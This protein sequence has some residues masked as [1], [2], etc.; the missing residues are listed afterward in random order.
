MINQRTLKKAHLIIKKMPSA[1]RQR[2]SLKF[3]RFCKGVCLVSFAATT[4]LSFA[5][6]PEANDL[7]QTVNQALAHAPEW[8]SQQIQTAA[9][10]EVTRQVRS[11]L[12]PRIDLT[13][14]TGKIE[15]EP[16]GLEGNNN[17]LSLR[18]SQPLINLE[19]WFAYQASK[20][21]RSRLS[22]E[23]DAAL[24]NFMIEIAETYLSV[25]RAESQ[26]EFVQA[27]LSA[28]Q[29]QLEQTQQRFRVGLIAITDVHEAQAANDL[30]AVS[31]IAANT[32]L[33]IAM[34]NLSRLTG[35]YIHDV[36]NLS[37]N[38]PIENPTPNNM[39]EWVKIAQTSNPSIKAAEQAAEITKTNIREAR[40][41]YSPTVGLF[42]TKADSSNSPTEMELDTTEVGLQVNY[43]LFQGLN[44]LSQNKQASMLH[45]AAQE[46]LR[47][48]KKDITQTTRN[49]FRSVQTD[50]LRVE[51]RLQAIR[52]SESA[53]EA[54]EA[55]YEVGTRN[56]VDVL[57]AQR[58]L[59]AAKRDLASAKYDYILNGLRLE[60]ATG[61]LT[62]E[63]LAKLN[64]WFNE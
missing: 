59:F 48:I 37:A 22:H 56:I 30:A 64:E 44:V 8:Q 14:Q 12:L 3:W 53:L 55:G 28:T 45:H 15:Y 27:E 58:S 18:L 61:S 20:L 38:F 32:D 57:N 33:D 46:D 10:Q 51:A 24:H 9:N 25:L 7:L 11:A 16:S 1:L 35:S 4:S 5:A 40:S 52:S 19:A 43:T 50:V 36:Q 49:L 21:N 34:E 39:P 63:T 47:R 29:Q 60:Q 2:Q 13:G 62:V 6:N 54:T 42:A 26:L 23:L 41:K 17:S 31:R